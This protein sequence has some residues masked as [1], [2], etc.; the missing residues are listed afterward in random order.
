MLKIIFPLLLCSSVIFAMSASD[1]QKATA[2]ELGCIKGLGDKRLK[3]IINY[4]QKNPIVKLEDLLNI[5]GIGKATINNIKENIKK[6]ICLKDKKA[7]NIQQKNKRKKI[8]AK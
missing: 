1:V 6:K 4:R 2:K 8:G 3:A 5:R 7:T